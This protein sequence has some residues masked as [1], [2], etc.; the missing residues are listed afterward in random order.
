MSQMRGCGQDT[1]QEGQEIHS[2][3]QTS[4]KELGEAEPGG[5]HTGWLLEGLVGSRFPNTGCL[6]APV[7][8]LEL[9]WGVRRG[10]NRG[11]T[12]QEAVPDPFVLPPGISLGHLLEGLDPF[13]TE[14]LTQEKKTLKVSE[15]RLSAPG[16]GNH[17]RKKFVL[18][19]TMRII[20]TVSLEVC[21]CT[22]EE[23]EP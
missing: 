15:K 22:E 23:A 1:S 20:F 21:A 6:K 19:G 9:E 10:G 12:F 16:E 3:S 7:S 5:S 8:P 2:A 18:S 17:T 11:L 4:R 14:G 13:G